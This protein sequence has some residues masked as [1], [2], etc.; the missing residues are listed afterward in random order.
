MGGSLF[1][2][3]LVGILYEFLLIHHRSLLQSACFFSK[4]R[5]K[6]S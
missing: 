5:R 3:L 6:S 2:L 1:F 4:T